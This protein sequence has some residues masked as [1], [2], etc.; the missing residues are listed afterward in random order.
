M[1]LL[2]VHSGNLYGGVETIL[3]TLARF[4]GTASLEHEFALCFE[5][6]LAA[7][8]RAG[9]TPLHWIGAVRTR[10]P[11]GV[12]RAR[13]R[14]GELLRER[15]FDAVACHM[16]WA[17][18]LFG[19]VARSGGRPLV[20]WMHGEATG[21]H[22][23][24]RW[25]RR[26]PPD[27]VLCNSHYTA[28]TAQALYPRSP[29]EVLYPPVELTSSREPATA[30]AALRRE[31]ATPAEAVVII[32]TS[33][34]EPGKGQLGHLEAL[35]RLRDLPQWVAWFVGGAQRPA[36]TRY[37][38]QLRA[39]AAELEITERV[40]FCG[41]RADVRDLLGAADIFCQPNLRPEP[42]GIVFVEALDAGLPIVTADVGGAVEI[43]DSSC[44]LCEPP[45]DPVR[46]AR[47]LR[48]LIE[49]APLRDRLARG[50]PAR[51]VTLCE[52]R[53][54]VADLAAIV[55]RF[56]P[57]HMAERLSHGATEA[58]ERLS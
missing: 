39:R 9:R 20:F 53:A 17:Q 38:A 3:T 31:L 33:R 56:V 6:R 1:R 37:L 28:E 2:H 8:L 14:L 41:E 7:E 19:P 52:P 10:W 24:E 36:D 55:A 54:R 30:H 13:H 51:A 44:G 45:N 43:V 47:A 57:G 11:L 50:G 21:R 26:T 27:L 32:Q 25:A 29:R 46:L 18:A 42:F 58:A 5:G 34:L 23:L 40:R 35:G 16:P 4:S 48:R 49:D 22:W 15:H 12:V